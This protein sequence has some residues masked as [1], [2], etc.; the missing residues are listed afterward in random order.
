MRVYLSLRRRG[1]GNFERKMVGSFSKWVKEINLCLMSP[2]INSK[3]NNL[4]II[5]KLPKSTSRKIAL[6]TTREDHHITHG[7]PLYQ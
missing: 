5:L 3:E 1:K 7:E 4:S 2:K 6:K